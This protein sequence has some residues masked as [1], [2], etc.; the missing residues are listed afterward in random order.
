[1]LC[2]PTPNKQRLLSDTI[3]RPLLVNSNH[4]STST[5]ISISSSLQLSINIC[6]TAKN[7]TVQNDAIAKIQ[8]ATQQMLEYKQSCLLI[9]NQDF[10][11]AKYFVDTSSSTHIADLL[12]LFSDQQLAS[13]LLKQDKVKPILV[14]LVDGEPD[15]NPRYF[16]NII[17]YCNLFCVLEFDYLTFIEEH[18]C[19]QHLVKCGQPQNFNKFPTQ[20]SRVAE[21]VSVLIEYR[22]DLIEQMYTHTREVQFDS[23]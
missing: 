10:K 15:K 9:S 12:I 8:E 1:T 7:A 3:I 2:T 17:E 16:K 6:V 13:T 19:Y 23:E 22:E 20:A 4:A 21:D 18:K 5:P 11:N 14:L